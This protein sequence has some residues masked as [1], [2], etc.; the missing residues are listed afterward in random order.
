[1]TFEEP[2]ARAVW[3]KFLTCRNCGCEVIVAN[4]ADMAQS[5]P[6]FSLLAG[7]PGGFQFACPNT[8]GAAYVAQC[9]AFRQL[10]HHA[11]S[12]EY[13]GEN[14][15]EIRAG[16]RHPVALSPLRRKRRLAPRRRS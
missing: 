5:L 8:C 15:Y 1:M 3:P 6:H 16:Q 10:F 2:G 4:F 13:G 11:P 7:I 14:V 12:V 9:P